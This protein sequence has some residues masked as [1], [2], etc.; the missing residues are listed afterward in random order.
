M[1]VSKGP[2]FDPLLPRCALNSLRACF[3][4]LCAKV[5]GACLDSLFIML[6]FADS[7]A[8]QAFNL[9]PREEESGRSLN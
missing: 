1:S 4:P 5:A 2:A 7:H 8:V 9:S 6:V 3:N